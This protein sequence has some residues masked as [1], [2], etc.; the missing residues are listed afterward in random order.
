MRLLQLQVFTLLNF[1][2]SALEF[3]KEEHWAAT[4]L[5]N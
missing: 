4:E 1:D 2:V 5:I 3:A